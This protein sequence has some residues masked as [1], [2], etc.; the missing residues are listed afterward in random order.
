MEE[1]VTGKLKDEDE[2]WPPANGTASDVANGRAERRGA[3][4]R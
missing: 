4:R 2:A 1:R 3:S